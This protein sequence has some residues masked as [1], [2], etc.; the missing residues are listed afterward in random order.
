MMVGTQEAAK[1][2]SK[3]V[4]SNSL[5]PKGFKEKQGNIKEW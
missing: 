1:D 4:V 3:D 2:K 5:T